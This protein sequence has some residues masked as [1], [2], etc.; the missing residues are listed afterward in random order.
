MSAVSAPVQLIDLEPAPAD[1]AQEAIVGLRARPKTLPCKLFYDKRGSELFET[2]CSLPEYYPTRTE[3][4]IMRRKLAAIAAAIGPRVQLVELGSGSSRKTRILLDAL[5]D[6]VAYTPIDISREHL[7]ESAEAIHAAYPALQVQAVCADYT[8]PLVIPEPQ[9]RPDRRIAF[10]P[11]STIGNFHASD[12]RRFLA[13][14]ARMVGV[15]GGLLIGVDLRKSEDVLVAAYDDAQGVTAEFNLNS[16]HRLNREVGADFAVDQFRHR[17]VWNAEYGR[18]EMH[19][20]SRVDQRVAIDG[21]EFAFAADE[22]I[23]TECAY[24]YDIAQFAD[25][26]ERFRVE[27]VWTDDRRRFSVQYLV[28]AGDG[29]EGR[30]AGARGGPEVV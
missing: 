17:S 2:I 1:L 18:I 20:V 26:A 15:G 21:H 22:S 12:A 24:K 28:V 3:I 9:R 27:H 7:W 8:E 19:L 23:R 6:P 13:R 4:G 29:R 25:I 14:I 16:L 11:G 10:F 5:E 30:D